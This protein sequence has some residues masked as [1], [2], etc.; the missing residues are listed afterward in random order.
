[1]RLFD[2]GLL[3]FSKRCSNWTGSKGAISS[4]TFAG[5]AMMRNASRQNHE[6]LCEVGRMPSSSSLEGECPAP[7]GT[8]GLSR[9]LR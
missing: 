5:A 6:S 2:Q 4:S 3:H 7:W 8:S 1:M 9:F